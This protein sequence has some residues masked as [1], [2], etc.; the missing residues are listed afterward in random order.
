M[1]TQ[2]CT[3]CGG[4][5]PLGAAFCQFCGNPLAP[6]PTGGMATPPL[7][8]SPGSMAPP[9]GPTGAPTFGPGGGAAPP[10]R[11]RSRLRLIVILV[12][13]IVVISLVGLAVYEADQTVNVT[14]INFVSPDNTCGWNGLYDN[15]FN[16]PP[17]SSLQFEYENY[18]NTTTGN[19][20]GP[21]TVHSVT[22][23]TSGFS[24]SDANVPLY[25]PANNTTTLD[26]TVN[27]PNSP[28]NGPLWI[29][30]T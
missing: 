9:G 28:Y 5:N 10:P 17:G 7:A 18:G 29:V 14:I 22:T 23:N 11:P 6:L 27:L 8:S 21:C 19:A 15:G 12:V 2:F 16:E 26:F 4:Q 13:V 25:T 3:H 30:I 1:A 24:I 20:T